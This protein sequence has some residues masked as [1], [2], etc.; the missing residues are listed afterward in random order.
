MS[1]TIYDLR[2]ELKAQEARAQVQTAM[3]TVGRELGRVCVSPDEI[4]EV[5][6]QLSLQVTFLRVAA[7]ALRECETERRV[8]AAARE[9]EER[10]IEW[11][12][13]ARE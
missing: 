8:L 2:P 10:R 5:A 6:L 13:A 9:K 12:P 4:E 1:A 11:D 3:E 7:R